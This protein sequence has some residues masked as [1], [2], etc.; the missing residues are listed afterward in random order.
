[1]AQKFL[2]DIEVTRGLVDSSGDLGLAG[3]VLSST[4][5]GT[6]WITNEANSTVVYQDGFT[7]DN[8]TVDFTL[9]VSVTDENVTQVY[10]DGVYQTK[11]TYSIAQDTLTFSTAPPLSADI[12]VITF[13][14]VATSDELQAGVMIIPVKNTHTA[15]IA[16]G[17]PVY[18]TGNVGSSARLQIA[19]ADASNSAKMPAAGLLLQTLAVN[20]E[21][22]VVTGGYLR[23]ITTDTID[24]TS[25]SSNDTVY[26]KSGGGLT[27]TKPTG[28]NLIQN[29]AKVARVASGNAGSLIVSSILRTNDVPN[30]TNDY[31]WLGNS[32][33]VAT[34]TEFTSTGRGLL[35][36][37]AEGTASGDG[38][39]AYNNSSGVFT[40][41]P[42][43]LGGLSGTTDDITEG[44]TNLYYT[45][46]RARAAISE[47]STQLS[48]N[49]TTGVLTYTQGDTD[50]VSEGATNLYFTTAR[51]RSSIS[52]GGDLSYN[53]TTGIMS[54]TTPTTIASLSNHDTDDLAEGAT[55]LYYTD[56]RVGSYLTTNNYVTS[57][58]TH[59][60]TNKSGN[61]SQWTNDS[62]Y[63]T[64]Y[65]ETDTLATVTGRGSTTSG[66]ITINGLMIGG[67]GAYSTGGTTDWNH[68]TNARSG[69]AH[70]L[71]LG[72]ATNGPGGS[73]YYHVLGF[74]YSSKNGSG[75]L[76]Q[77][78][79]PYTSNN[80][81]FR[82][83]YS[84]T[85]SG[86]ST[87]WNS[88]NDGSGSGLDADLLDGLHASSFLQSETD[89][90]QTVTNRGATTT[91][92]ITL[93]GNSN[94]LYFTGGNNRIYFS[95]YRAMEGSTTGSNLQIGEG[96]SLITIQDLLYVDEDIRSKGQIR[97][98]GW[99]NQP[100][101]SVTGH[102]V[103]IGVSPNTSTEGYILSYSRD[104]S[105]YGDLNFD[106]V[107]YH[108]NNRSSGTF[109]VEGS[110]RTPILYDSDDTTYYINPA[111]FS[112]MNGISFGVPGSGGSTSGRYLSIEGNAD[113]S[114]EGSA[115]IFF[116]EHNSS[117]AAMSKYGMSIGYRG[118]NTS[119]VGSD[120]NTWTGLGDVG[121]GEWGIWG[122]NNSANGNLAMWGPRDGTYVQATGSFRAPEFYDT[123]TTYYINPS[124][125]SQ[126]RKTNLIASG[127]GW[128]D[129]LNLYSSDASNRWNV[130]VDN[131]T[132]DYLRFAYN[133]SEKLRLQT[134]GEVFT[135]G[136]G[137]AGS[138]FRAPAF[139]HSGNTSYY[140]SP[141]NGT[142][143]ISA[144]L[145]GR[146][147]VGTFSASQTNT[148][149]AWIGRAHDRSA[150]VL[151]VQLGTGTGRKFEVVDYGW[152][153]VEFSADDSGIATAAGSFRAP[154]FYDS[155]ATSRYLNPNSTSV[156]GGINMNGTLDMQNNNIS[157][158]N[159]IVINDP[160]VGEGISWNNGNGWQI[161]EAPDNN[162]NAA[163]NLQFAT[164]T[165][166]RFRI[167]TT[168]STYSE[169]HYDLNNTGYYLDA[170]STSHF[171]AIQ[172]EQFMYHKGDTNTRFE[173]GGDNIKL[174]TG[175]TDRLEINNTNVHAKDIY[176][177]VSSGSSNTYG[178]GYLFHSIESS[179]ANEPILMLHN[180][181][182]TTSSQHYGL[183][184]VT[185]ANHNNTTSRFM[186]G[187]GGSSEKIKIYSNGNIQN[188]NNSYGQLSDINLKENII[189]ATPKLDEINQVRVVNFNYIDD[190]NEDGL[191]KKQIGVV[192]QELEEIFPGMVYECG[193][194]ETPTKAVKYS[195][196]VPMLIKA[197]QE[198]TQEVQTL[199]DQINGIN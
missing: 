192:A 87:I 114:G 172:I 106:A 169:R 161:Y 188:L 15:S 75:N 7:G 30:I 163:G 157:G 186:L 103:E 38:N 174:R 50:T 100:S 60:F 101:S 80:I 147:Q 190:L 56:A 179:R 146:I 117:T 153:T 58:S 164:G 107:N 138:D 1:M 143:G 45:D 189:D 39:L 42:P 65:T 135:I 41:T 165:T 177:K 21:G 144:N 104:N 28:S 68:S 70:T 96:F 89:T 32:S 6:N 162:S 166:H 108:F 98:T 55:N 77:I 35:S 52:A 85:W 92:A 112:R 49:S 16:K 26:V 142:N 8:S 149:E 195:V 46:A 119:I 110:I 191:P 197:V 93:D 17:E 124:G 61:I 78:G 132:G 115:R 59:T 84:G 184:I 88:G 25:T 139:Y 99:Y 196:F 131:G 20:A 11:D 27:M 116:A 173:F 51:A 97:A 167:D 82:T 128:D 2:T 91:N 64:G 18:I 63:I 76:L 199:K 54:Y 81:V 154:I 86:Y 23:N 36:V 72:N 31:F 118:G 102:A 71:L 171:N 83:R 9:S 69:Q 150:G 152:T 79:L 43:V 145:Q 175:G 141:G 5:T 151:T 183:N 140:V 122:H 67:L 109:E 48:Y 194:T 105:T 22:Y 127:S 170:A 62:G 125:T 33:G 198:L 34:P 185:A 19:P 47:N 180:T 134:D 111:S 3:Q 74:E 120:G 95:G 4:G 137:K 187:Q 90:L 94:G 44:S 113:S 129:G 121:N 29:I 12:E 159:H 168:G 136:T 181:V 126:I 193:D 40:Y 24:G 160:G 10:I 73:Q 148:G 53:S 66:S 14:T 130:L 13:A 123:N 158:V 155:A 156:L 178:S 182:A 176:F 37:G 57:S 133:N